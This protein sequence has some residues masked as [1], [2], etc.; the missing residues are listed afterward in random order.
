VVV[1]IKTE[2]LPDGTV[3]SAEIVDAQRMDADAA[4]RGVAISARRPILKCSSI[5]LPPDEYA[6]WESTTFRFAA[7]GMVE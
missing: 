6:L 1:E 5:K 4:F 3:K 7:Q 2:F